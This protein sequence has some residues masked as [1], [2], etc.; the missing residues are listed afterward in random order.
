MPRY[1]AV[2]AIQYLDPIA[3]FVERARVIQ[4]LLVCRPS[5]SWPET[6]IWETEVVLSGLLAI[7]K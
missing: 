6:A 4:R 7:R 2:I 5:G 3:A 1:R